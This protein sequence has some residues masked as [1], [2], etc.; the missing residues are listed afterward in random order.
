MQPL[1]VSQ[2]LFLVA[3]FL[4]L[5][6]LLNFVRGATTTMPYWQVFLC[7]DFASIIFL[8]YIAVEIHAKM[9]LR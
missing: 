4:L 1:L 6:V 8:L 3:L 9:S 7:C 2:T 5:R